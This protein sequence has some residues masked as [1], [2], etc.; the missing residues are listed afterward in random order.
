MQGNILVIGATGQI[1]IELVLAL[2]SK[3]GN[4][5]VI[6]SDIRPDATGLLADGPFETLNVLDKEAVKALVEKHSVVE[7]YQLA[8]LLS[9][10]SE[11]NPALAWDLNMNGLFHILDLAKTG[12][13]IKKVFWPS[14]IAA[15]GPTTPRHSTPQTTVME[16]TS[17]Y[18]IS[19]LA[20]ERWCEY[21][22]LKHGV[23]V[24]SIR[25]P[26]LIG[27]R[28]E[29][30][31]GT[32]D[33]AVDIFYHALKTGTYECFLSE[34]TELPMMMMEDA[35][36]ATIGIMEAPADAIK[37]RSSYNL[38]G[39]SFTPSQLADAIRHHIPNFTISYKPDFRQ[40]LADSWP[41]SIDDA[42]AATDWGWKPEYDLNRLVHA[43]LEGVR[44]KLSAVSS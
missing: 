19:K 6:A 15:F 43:M 32:T 22:H 3:F 14:S 20:G 41:C 27:F 5:R 21:Y 4:D 30:G 38:A 36:R 18:G 12:G 16:P 29:P 7:V 42:A 37:I 40:S 44:N 2:R 26:G 31:G 8:A 24:R 17:V 28:S 25:Y 10:T 33:Y 11:K 23:D 13:P 9:A 34:Q 39:V 1:G 35:I